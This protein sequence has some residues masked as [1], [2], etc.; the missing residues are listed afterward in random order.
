MLSSEEVMPCA[1]SKMLSI[2]DDFFLPTL[3][4]ALLAAPLVALAAPLAPLAAAL[5]PMPSN[6]PPRRAIVGRNRA[7]ASRGSAPPCWRSRS[8]CL[9]VNGAVVEEVLEVEVAPATLS[10][11][12]GIPLL[13]PSPLADSKFLLCDFPP[14]LLLKL[15]PDAA[16]TLLLLLPPLLLLLLLVC[17]DDGGSGRQSNIHVAGEQ[18]RSLHEPLMPSLV[19]VVG[20]NQLKLRHLTH[21]AMDGT[22]G[23]AQ[24]F[25]HAD[26]CHTVAVGGELGSCGNED[27]GGQVNRVRTVQSPS[28]LT[29]AHQL[30]RACGQP[31]GEEHVGAQG[32]QVVLRRRLLVLVH[33]GQI[34]LG[35]E[36]QLYLCIPA[37]R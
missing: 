26:C 37:T 30:V 25:A 19:E 21:H 32:P 23:A 17:A 15:R 1:T 34:S 11:L 9:A 8:S 13:L 12:R 29:G 27:A 31:E 4:L 2:T 24:G 7:R 35:G 16:P 5:D 6:R 10:G 14:L 33:A 28:D 3:F 18:P 36:R 22:R 20:E